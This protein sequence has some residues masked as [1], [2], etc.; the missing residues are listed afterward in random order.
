MNALQYSIFPGAVSNEQRNKVQASI[1]Q[2]NAKHFLILFRD[3]RTQY[4]GLYTW[5]QASDSVYRIVSF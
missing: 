2:S 4:R 5:D 1:A 3:Q